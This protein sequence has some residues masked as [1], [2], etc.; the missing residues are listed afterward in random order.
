MPSQ[1]KLNI[2]KK[3]APAEPGVTVFSV[4]RNEMYFLPHFL[5]H[6]RT[7]GVRDF[8]FLD[9]HSEDGTREFLL[10]QSDCGV[11]QSSLRFGDQVG[12]KSFGTAVKT[13]V[14]HELFQGR[15]VLMV[16]ADEFLVL[17]QAF[18][19]MDALAAALQGGSL[20]VAR[21]LM[22]DFLPASL[23][24]LTQAS[25]DT[26]PFA[27]CPYFDALSVLEWPDRTVAASRISWQESVRPRMLAKLRSAT[28]SVEL[29][30]ILKSY[31]TAN[32]NKAPLLFWQGDTQMLSA[33]RSSELPSDRVTLVL[34]HFKF[35]PGYKARIADALATKAHWASSVEYRFLDV[36]T[37]ELEDWPLLGPRSRSFSS[38]AD[39]E[40]AG[41][42]VSHLT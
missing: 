20:K 25:V 16:D 36:A 33:H 1:V 30:D 23:R 41:L 4:V 34:A 29:L 3:P 37:R 21:A 14:P 35:Y 31:K 11:I 13:I 6:Y 28:P 2:L 8:W 24:A 26:N 39:L 22:I 9:D 15:W 42:L 10:A 18:A 5:Q 38:P 32:V 17:P 19:S 27:L 12:Q 40:D 7:L